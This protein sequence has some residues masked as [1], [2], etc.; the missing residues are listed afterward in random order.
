[1]PKLYTAKGDDGT[2]GLLGAERVE[3]SD[4]R[5]EVLG[6]LDELS[7]S[8]GLSRSLSPAVISKELKLI[9][10]VIYEIMAEVASTKENEAQFRKINQDYIVELENKIAEYSD[11]V[12]LPDQFILPGDSTASAM[13]SLSRTVARRAERRLVK[14]NNQEKMGNPKLIPY[15]NRLS[16]FLFV[17]ELY[18][19]QNLDNKSTSFAKSQN[20]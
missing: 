17:I 15:M 13:I 6:T 9:Q 14:L 8:L 5:I 19:S 10:R 16:S 12:Q 4:L 2:T 3:K 20:R 7:A 11:K 1:M 18:L